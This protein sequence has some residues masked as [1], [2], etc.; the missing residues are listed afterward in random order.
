MIENH[1][2]YLKHKYFTSK[3]ILNRKNLK[4]LSKHIIS[5]SHNSLTY[6]DQKNHLISSISHMLQLEKL[7][8]HNH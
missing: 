7:I 8:D 2:L 5:S 6:T 3:V 4:S 1:R